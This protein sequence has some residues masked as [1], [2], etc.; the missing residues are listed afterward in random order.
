MPKP[1]IEDD[2]FVVSGSLYTLREFNTKKRK[3]TLT[4]NIPYRLEDVLRCGEV[5]GFLKGC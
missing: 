4:K 1:F 5:A 3:R 2:A